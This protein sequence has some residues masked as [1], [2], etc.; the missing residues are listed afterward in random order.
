[1]RFR[2]EALAEFE[3]EN[4]DDAFRVLAD[5]FNNL[6]HDAATG[7]VFLPDSSII[8][9]PCGSF[10]EKV[11]KDGFPLRQKE[12]EPDCKPKEGIDC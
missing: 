3:A 9:E 12:I 8:I 6:Y 4:I 1:M 7:Q 5:Y 10:S 2:L 11:Q